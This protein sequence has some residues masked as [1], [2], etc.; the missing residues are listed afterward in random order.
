MTPLTQD[1]KDVWNTLKSVMDSTVLVRSRLDGEEVACICV[2]V[3]DERQPIEAG[4][5][6]EGMYNMIP[7]A[8]LITTA[9]MERMEP[10]DAHTS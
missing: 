4:E 8:V 1:E 10:P 7:V 2:L 9:I 6:E 5:L 3:D